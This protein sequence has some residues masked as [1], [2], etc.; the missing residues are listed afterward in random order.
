MHAKSFG[1]AGASPS[2]R[3]AAL[4]RRPR[5]AVAVLL[6][7]LC[8]CLLLFS[9]LIRLLTAPTPLVDPGAAPPSHW[10][11]EPGPYGLQGGAAVKVITA[12]HFADMVAAARRH[13]RGRRMVD[14]TREP[15]RNTLQSLVNTWTE[16]SY[17]AVHCHLTYAET[18]VVLDG[19]LA[20]FTWEADSRDGQVFHCTVLTPGAG[21][22]AIVVEA[23]TY[24]AMTA[25]PASL[26]G[27]G[28]AL[29][30]E[31]SGHTFRQMDQ[32]KNLAPWA[33]FADQGND[34]DPD[35]F[36]SVLL[37]RCRRLVP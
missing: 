33:P 28:H 18:F 24:H 6:A 3:L 20:F 31:T 1:A 26:G 19:A 15:E 4:V 32:N 37:P 30:F 7:V 5:V 8:L 25:L 35:Y 36:T 23:G 9:D 29:V 22:R 11:A 12:D 13:P 10:P 27:P 2:S 17:S 14:L 16:G 34:G 21:S